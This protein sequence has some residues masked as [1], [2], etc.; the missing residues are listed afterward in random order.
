MKNM[1][2][3]GLITKRIALLDMKYG[4]ACIVQNGQLISIIDKIIILKSRLD[5]GFLLW[6]NL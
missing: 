4:I 5:L 3:Y 6:R 1:K 2:H